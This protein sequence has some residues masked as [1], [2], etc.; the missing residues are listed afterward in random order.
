MDN[1]ITALLVLSDL[2][3]GSG[4]LLLFNPRKDVFFFN[5]K[6]IIFFLFL[7]VNICCGYSIEAP[8]RGASIEYPQHMH[9]WRNKKNIYRDTPYLELYVAIEMI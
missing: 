7:P 9:L 2:C 6:V 3:A 4:Y 5:Q 1:L 8:R